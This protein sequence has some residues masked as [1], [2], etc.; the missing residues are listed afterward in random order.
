MGQV[1][2]TRTLEPAAAPWSGEIFCLLG[3]T[4]VLVLHSRGIRE[5][6][7]ARGRDYKGQSQQQG[8]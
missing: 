7:S 6:K 1:F 4:G 2:N 3:A 8:E 5:A